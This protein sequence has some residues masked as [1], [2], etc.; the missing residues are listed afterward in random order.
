MNNRKTMV[1]SN[2]LLSLSSYS[3]RRV[4]NT[5]ANYLSSSGNFKWRT[6]RGN[7]CFRK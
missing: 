7:T 6:K 4:Q 1:V 3:E 2:S 5:H